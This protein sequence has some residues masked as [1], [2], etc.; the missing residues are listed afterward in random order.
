MA[1]INWLFQNEQ[2]TNLN[3]YKAKNVSTGEEVIFDL[4][5]NG[6][7]SVVGTPLNAENMNSLINA[8]NEVYDNFIDNGNIKVKNYESYSEITPYRVSNTFGDYTVRLDAE[9][10]GVGVENNETGDYSEFNIDS[11]SFK[12]DSFLYDFKFPR[13]QG[14]TLLVGRDLIDIKPNT[15]LLNKI[16][17]NVIQ[18]YDSYYKEK[19]NVYKFDNDHADGVS[20]YM[21]FGDTK[22]QTT[23]NSMFRPIWNN[24][25]GNRQFAMLDDIS[26]SVIT[27]IF[28]GKDLLS[29]LNAHLSNDYSMYIIIG[30][31]YSINNDDNGPGY[32]IV[33]KHL[34]DKIWWL[35][36]M[37]S[38]GAGDFFEIQANIISNGNVVADVIDPDGC[39]IT[40]IYAFK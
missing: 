7:I 12:K 29:N 22:I 2:G 27:K 26:S 28:E 13:T 18:Q 11:I 30:D 5:R 33:Q 34:E 23:I 1:K 17:D 3:R 32:A 36:G 16:N 40:S 39:Q 37:A 6:T 38:Y 19:F 4:F 10:G 9:D 15:I 14:E 8:I 24:G 21:D 20:G 31:F 35:V 25:S